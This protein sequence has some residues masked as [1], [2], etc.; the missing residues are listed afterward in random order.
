MRISFL[1]GPSHCHWS[2]FSMAPLA[3]KEPKSKTSSSSIFDCVD[4][5]CGFHTRAFV[6]STKSNEKHLINRK[7]SHRTGMFFPVDYFPSSMAGPS[8]KNS[9][10]IGGRRGISSRFFDVSISCRR[11][12]LDAARSGP[13]AAAS[14]FRTAGSHAL[15]RQ[16]SHCSTRRTFGVRRPSVFPWGEPINRLCSGRS[17]DP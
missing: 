2:P 13:P 7:S 11:T 9:R 10:P 14:I 6:D 4:C 3:K 1:Q 15:G 17:A 12:A 5:W 8:K 16:A